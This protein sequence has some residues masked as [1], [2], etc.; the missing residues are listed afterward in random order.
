MMQEIRKEAKKVRFVG[1]EARLEPY[2]I[3]ELGRDQ[4]LVK[5]RC[6]LISIGTETTALTGR[7]NNEWFR[8][9]PGYALAGDVI[10]VGEDVSTFQ[11]GDRVCSEKNHC[12]YGI[13]STVPNETMKI[14]EGVSY[15]ESTFLG[16]SAVALHAVRRAQIR[17]GESLLIMGA[18]IVGMLVYEFARKSGASPIIFSDL[19]QR[20]LDF[21]KKLG[22]DGV[23]CP[24][25]D[26]LKRRTMDITGKDGA[27]VVIEAV[28]NPNILQ[29][30]MKL[31]ASGG[32]VV[33]LGALAGEIA[34]LD[35]FEDFITR[36]LTL[37]AAQQPMNPTVGNLYYSFTKLRERE[38]I[39]EQMKKKELDVSR[40][41]THRYPCTQIP[42]VYETLKNGKN[43]DYA[44]QTH[45]ARDLIGVLIDWEK[46]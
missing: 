34:H 35:L 3:G 25:T 14:P 44:V 45:Q 29:D 22:A 7:W 10:A 16:L 24:H 32:R 19:S 1:Q 15:E 12:N 39:F 11:V 4:I 28:G 33:S 26:D 13:C 23:L 31:C 8:E 6:S 2:D 46:S 36:E 20:R 42:A 21:V 9:N 17:I 38:Y 40:F 37:V 18:G 30:A 27:D 41:I 43:A 5:T